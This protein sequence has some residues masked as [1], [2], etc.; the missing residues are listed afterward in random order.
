[1][2]TCL[3]AMLACLTITPAFAGSIECSPS[4]DHGDACTVQIK[5]GDHKVLYLQPGEKE[6]EVI[7]APADDGFRFAMMHAGSDSEAISMLTI[8]AVE[9]NKSST[10]LISSDRGFREL[11]LASK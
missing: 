11:D 10:V 3:I 7:T 4:M 1:M 9:K 2:K 5:A 6:N 8:S